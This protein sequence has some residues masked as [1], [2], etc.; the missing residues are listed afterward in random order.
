MPCGVANCELFLQ[1]DGSSRTS[2]RKFYSCIEAQEFAKQSANRE[3]KYHFEIERDG[4]L[5]TTIDV[6]VKD[7]KK[8]FTS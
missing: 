7:G 6:E 2:I 3:G 4:K 8:N 5:V 1:K